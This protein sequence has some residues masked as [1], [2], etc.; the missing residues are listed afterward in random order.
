MIGRLRPPIDYMKMNIRSKIKLNQRG[1]TLIE[2][3]ISIFIFSVVLIGILTLS[4]STMNSYNKAR[5]IKITKE[6]AEYAISLIAK[7]VRM[8]SISF[9]SAYSDGTPQKAFLV[10]RN[11]GG[12]V[13]YLISADNKK[14]SACDSTCSSCSL[15]IMDLEGTFSEFSSGTSF[16]SCPTDSSETEASSCTIGDVTKKERGWVEMNLNIV[17]ETTYEAEGDQINIQTTVSVRDYG[18]END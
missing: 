16:R 10:K 2:L 7:D 6:S 18:W 4:V 8:G 11:G 1:L 17:P 15:D 13:C 14:L 12:E 5:T 9:D 3:M